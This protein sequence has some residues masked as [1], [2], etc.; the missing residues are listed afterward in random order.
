[1]QRQAQWIKL[2][3]NFDLQFD[4]IR[5]KDNL[6]ADALSRKEIPDDP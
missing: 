5:G 3:A 2:L 4:Y 1:L 6:V